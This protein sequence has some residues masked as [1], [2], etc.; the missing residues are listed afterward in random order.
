MPAQALSSFLKRGAVPPAEGTSPDARGVSPVS[1]RS[2]PNWERASS[3]R[4]GTILVKRR[5]SPAARRSS[6]AKRRTIPMATRAIRAERR[7]IPEGQGTSFRP[8]GK[9]H[10][11]RCFLHERRGQTGALLAFSGRFLRRSLGLCRNFLL[12]PDFVLGFGHAF[13]PM[14]KPAD[15][16]L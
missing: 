6:F 15:D 16:M 7:T 9:S 1:S 10:E 14:I 3:V 2:G 8:T 5:T 4:T 13:E 12:S 11:A